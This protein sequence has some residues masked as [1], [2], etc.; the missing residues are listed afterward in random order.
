MTDNAKSQI[1]LALLATRHG[2]RNKLNTDWMTTAWPLRL[3][4]KD[5]TWQPRKSTQSGLWEKGSRARLS[6]SLQSVLHQN[7]TQIPR[8]RRLSDQNKIQHLLK[9]KY[10]RE[11][12]SVNNT[13]NYNELFQLFFLIFI[14][15]PVFL[16]LTHYIVFFLMICLLLFVFPSII[17]FYAVKTCSCIV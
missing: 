14:L 10:V 2:E 3:V 9:E 16:V 15:Y 12:H 11:C 6:V 13:W 8:I 7:K 5:K 17:V 1:T 4:D